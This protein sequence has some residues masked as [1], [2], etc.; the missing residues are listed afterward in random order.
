MNEDLINS[1]VQDVSRKAFDGMP[2]EDIDAMRVDLKNYIRECALYEYEYVYEHRPKSL[3]D[4]TDIFVQEFVHSVFNR[5]LLT[6][7]PDLRL[8]KFQAWMID[9]EL[10]KFDKQCDKMA[11]ASVS[12]KSPSPELDIL[13]AQARAHLEKYYEI[14]R[15]LKEKGPEWEERYKQRWGRQLSECW[16][17]INYVLGD[18]KA[19]SLRLGWVL[20]SKEQRKL[21]N[22][23]RNLWSDLLKR[24]KF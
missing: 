17:D 9:N 10:Y 2:Q 12:V 18:R 8:E 7:S 22:V 4:D 6:V 13:K 14:R 11:I 1:L 19:A 16:L 15:M 20:E 3:A 24:I 21:S 23:L 5:N